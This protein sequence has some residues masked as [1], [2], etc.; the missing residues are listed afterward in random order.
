ML[1]KRDEMAEQRNKKCRGMNAM[2]KLHV[3]LLAIFFALAIF[4]IT[5][6]VTLPD[7]K[8][9]TGHQEPVVNLSDSYPEHP[10]TLE[11]CENTS[12]RNFCISDLAEITNNASLCHEISDVDIEVF[13]R[14]STSLNESLCNTMKDSG[15][16]EA[17]IESI[18]IK[19]GWMEGN[20]S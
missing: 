17:C 11:D 20:V 2:K 12:K 16:T 9:A 4:V 18:K 5:F 15:L 3:L 8:A 14:A 1:Q 19:R 13:C 10:K 7:N 6:P